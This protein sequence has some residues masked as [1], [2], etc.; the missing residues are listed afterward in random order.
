MLL[1]MIA[2]CTKGE[3]T[4]AAAPPPIDAPGGSAGKPSQPGPPAQRPTAS[5]VL[6]TPSGPNKVWVE[7]VRKQHDIR[8]G[9]MF[10][11]HLPA[12]QGMLF[13]MG[14]E[15]VHTFY[16]RNT[17]IPLDMIFIGRDLTVAG[18]VE[19]A[20][21]RDETSRDVGKPSLYVLEVNGG[22]S[23]AHGVGPGTKVT[24]ENVEP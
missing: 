15:R 1:V 10:R 2:G 13:L 12:D 9:L 19:N 11:E 23:K 4:R 6:E 5:V 17:L 22:W 24:F 14:E 3:P 8:R 7:I 18:V 20:V 21:P 16:M